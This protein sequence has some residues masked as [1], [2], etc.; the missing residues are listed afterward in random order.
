MVNM[1]VAMREYWK[2]NLG[3]ELDLLKRESGMPR[4][5][6]SQF[7][8]ISL[9]SWIPDPVQIVSNLTRDTHLG[10]RGADSP[11]ATAGRVDR[12]RA[13]AAPGRSG[14]LRRVPGGGRGVHGQSVH[15]ADP[16]GRRREVA[17]AAVGGRLREHEQRRHQHAALDVRPGALGAAARMTALPVGRQPRDGENR[18]LFSVARA[19]LYNGLP[20]RAESLMAG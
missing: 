13:V 7:Y 18:R 6:A 15:D 10:D 12:A 19:M 2:D 14:A 17:R 8:R 11:A 4:R 20:N 1:G 9:G 16:L 3:V 5:E